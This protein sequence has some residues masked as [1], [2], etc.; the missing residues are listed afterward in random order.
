MFRFFPELQAVEKE[1]IRLNSE[2]TIEIQDILNRYP[3]EQRY[4]LAILQEM[5]KTYGYISVDSLTALSGH[6]NVPLSELFSLATF[7]KSLSLTKKGKFIIK[8]CDG[9]ACHIRGSITVLEEIKR[10]LQIE[11]GET[12][13]DGLFSLE[14]VNCVGSCAMA[15]VVICGDEYFGNV[16]QGQSAEMIKEVSQNAK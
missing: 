5:Q 3:K 16:K 7:Y 11:E 10:T 9:T 1:V 12:T 6:V 15:P 2:K 13:A 4:S 8:V 14:V